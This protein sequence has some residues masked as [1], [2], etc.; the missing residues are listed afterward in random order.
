[1]ISK[2]VCEKMT[3]LKSVLFLVILHVCTVQLMEI[4]YCLD[5]LHSDNKDLNLEIVIVRFG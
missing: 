3:F 4:L 1:M 5:V 2:R